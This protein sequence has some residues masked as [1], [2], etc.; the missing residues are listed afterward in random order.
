MLLTIYKGIDM[1]F[2]D[3]RSPKSPVEHDTSHPDPEVAIALMLL[4]EIRIKRESSDAPSSHVTPEE[5]R[6][7]RIARNAGVRYN[8]LRSIS[9]RANK[10]IKTWGEGRDEK[11]SR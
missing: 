1:P 5:A 2:R 6:L 4:Q 11:F 7:L 8:R 9:G 10:T 3:W